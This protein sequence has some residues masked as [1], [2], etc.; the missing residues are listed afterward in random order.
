MRASLL[1]NNTIIPLNDFVQ[2][3]VANILFAIAKSFGNTP[4][5]VIININPDGIRIFTDSEEMSFKGD[6]AKQ[7]I[8]NT[9]KG[10]LSPLKGVFWQQNITITAKENNTFAFLSEGAKGL[11]E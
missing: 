5:N 4:S 3:Y 6:F 9:I 11:K 2:D 7:M 8:E 10:M 1:V